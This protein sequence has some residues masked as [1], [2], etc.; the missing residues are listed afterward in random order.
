[1]NLTWPQPDPLP[2]PVRALF[3]QLRHA[4]EVRPVRCAR[5]ARLV[6]GEAGRER[7]GTRVRFSLCVHGEQLTRVRFRAY[8]CPYTLAACEWVALRLESSGEDLR[9]AVQTLG[10]PAEWA[11]A[12]QI[13][14]D[15]LGR[16]LVI[17][18]ALT[19]ALNEL[20]SVPADNGMTESL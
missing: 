1:M 20:A 13:P 15:R 6:H 3:G 7:H 10:P 17:E 19:A 16:L 9:L 12:L 5:G 11:G 8:G 18:D 2:A 4:A 14:P